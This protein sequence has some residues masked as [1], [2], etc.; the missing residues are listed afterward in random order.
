[1]GASISHIL[2]GLHGLLQIYVLYAHNGNE[3]MGN[4]QNHK[5]LIMS[6]L[7]TNR[8]IFSIYFNTIYFNEN[9]LR[10]RKG[11]AG[12]DKT[13]WAANPKS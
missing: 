11:H 10:G 4:V 3:D 9:K 13:E 1:M 7:T 5:N 12:P 8:M 2:T 6:W